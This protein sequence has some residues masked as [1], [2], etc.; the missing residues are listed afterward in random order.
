MLLT[1]RILLVAVQ[2]LIHFWSVFSFYT[3]IPPKTPKGF[4]G[5]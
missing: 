2:I 4:Q 5:V 3:S 1:L